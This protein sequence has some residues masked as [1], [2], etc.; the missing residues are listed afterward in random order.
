MFFLRILA[1]AHLFPHEAE[2][3][4][5]IF[6]ARQLSAMAAE[7]A[8]ITVLVPRLYCPSWLRKV[9][10]KPAS[11]N[12]RLPLVSVPGLSA[13]PV[14]YLGLPGIGF[15]R[16][17]G[18][19]VYLAIRRHALRLHREKN[20]DAIYATEIFV[21]GDAA[22]RLASRM[23]VPAACLAIGSD[24]NVTA[25]AST[26]LSRH[27]QRV[28]NGLDGNLACG[29]LA[30]AEIDAF[31][32]KRKTLCVY[33]V[34]DLD[35]FRP[36]A[37]RR[38]VR[39]EL[40]LPI[41]R[42][43]VLYVGY[44]WKRKGLLELIEA[45]EAIQPLHP[46]CTLVICGAGNEQHAIQTAARQSSAHD[47]IR[48]IGNV[49]PEHIHRVFQACDLFV[50]PSHAEG[51]PNAV[52]EAMACG[53]PVVCTSVG[54]IPE[55]LGDNEGAIQVPPRDARALVTAIHSVLA[56]ESRRDRMASAARQLAVE[57]FG[58]R[59]NAQKILN[60]LAEMKR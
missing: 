21:N 41:D 47:V 56:D 37:D 55:A 49:D 35:R 3:R 5:G 53:L 27:F 52:M 42:K 10:G 6:V 11:Y 29:A 60:Y 50:L 43:L 54:G 22:R 19:S 48:F 24:I 39:D 12:H 14:P 58:A 30:A 45:F 32:P 7:G 2:R 13:I 59:R 34:V 44:L 51:M 26:V 33:G 40:D 25:R 15:N 57:K 20:V 18:L 31:Q 4:Y 9:L 36:T 38:P 23:H 16:W 46:D 1:I 8:E 28:V 17:S